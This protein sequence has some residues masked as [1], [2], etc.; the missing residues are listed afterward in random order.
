MA[1]LVEFLPSTQPGIR[2]PALRKLDVVTHTYKPAPE[3]RRWE[4]QGFKVIFNSIVG[5]RPAS[6]IGDIVSKK[7]KGKES[8]VTGSTPTYTQTCVCLL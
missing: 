3:R 7:K 5:S 2:S 6:A 8:L 4:D 1:Q